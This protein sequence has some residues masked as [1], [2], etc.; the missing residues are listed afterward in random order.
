MHTWTD[1][2][3]G[4]LNAATQRL[5]GGLENKAM[6][7][8]YKLKDDP[9]YLAKIIR[10]MSNGGYG[11]SVKESTAREIMGTNF[12]S[13]ADVSRY[14]GI[15]PTTQDVAVFKEVIFS[16]E[17][18]QSCK[19]THLLLPVLPLSILDMKKITQKKY[20][21]EN[22]FAQ[23]S[24]YDYVSKKFANQKCESGWQ[25]IRKDPF[26]NP[27]K[28]G[29]HLSV[30]TDGI[31]EDE[32]LAPVE[33]VIYTM[34]CHFLCRKE[35]LFTMGVHCVANG[36]STHIYTGKSERGIYIDELGFGGR[37]AA[38]CTVKK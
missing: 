24:S 36:V 9:I 18:L 21:G 8:A 1:I 15:R 3:T 31:P 23:N 19:D 30:N 2:P 25:L 7:V 10:A 38:L 13:V 35:N 20:E 14:F 26:E 22:I 29:F 16:K 37:D 11:L 12:F 34:I 28:R 6:W 27:G 17:V 33:L 4:I 5:W 32:E